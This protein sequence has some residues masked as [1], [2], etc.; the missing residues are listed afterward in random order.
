MTNPTIC[1]VPDDS[2]WRDVLASGATAVPRWSSAEAPV[3]GGTVTT[4][5]AV[6]AELAAAVFAQAG[7]LGV[8]PDALLLAA[9]ARVLAALTAEP[10]VLAGVEV[11]GR[12]LPCRLE[13]GVASWRVLV[14]TAFGA[15]T[16][17]RATD[18]TEDAALARARR[19]LAG[20]WPETVLALDP[21]DTAAETAA[22]PSLDDGVVFRIDRPADDLLRV[23]HRPGDLDAAAAERIAGY[24]LAA[25][26][27]LCADPDA[28]P[29]A[30]GLVGPDELAF[31]VDGLAGP[32]RERPAKPA[33]EIFRDRA[34]ADPDRVAVVNGERSWT[35]RELDE[36]TDRVARAILARG[37]PA[38]GIVAVVAERTLDWAAS[39]LGILKAGA[40]YLPLEP[41]FPADRIATV[42]TR[43]DARLVLG[44]RG[45]TA[46]LD[47][48]LAGLGA[49]APER[50][51][52]DDAV[53]EEHGDAVPRVDIAGDRLAYLYF[54]SGSTGEPKGAMCEHA[55]MVNH[56][57]AKIEDLGI[58][59]GTVVTETAPQCFDISLWQLV[60]P[61]LVGATTV[62]VEQATILDVPAFVELLARRRVEV[63][64]LVPSYLDVVVSY[65]EQQDVPAAEVLPAL[66]RIAVTG[67]AV[68]KELVARW[69]SVRPDVAMV[70][71]YGLTET[72][73]DTNHEILTEVPAGERVPLGPA[74]PNVRVYV[75]DEAL[76]PVPLGAPGEIVFSGVCVGRGY[77]NDPDRTAKA[78]VPDPLRAGERLYR[79]GD[80]GRWL[81]SGKLDFLGRRDHQVKISGFRIEIGEVENTLLR[82]PGV[83]DAAVV[84]AERP[85]R[86]KQLVGFYGAAAPVENEVLRATLGASLPGYMV[87]P[88]LHH[89]EVLPLTPNGKID[90]KALTTLA[91]ALDEPETAADADTTPLSPTEERVAAVW[92]P[93][94]GVDV[95]A[96]GRDT[97][98]FDRGGSSL[99][100]VKMAVGLKKVVS[101]PD[102]V[103]HPVLADLAALI[104]SKAEVPAQAPAPA[105]APAAA[106][107]AEEAPTVRFRPSDLTP[108]T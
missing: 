66:R 29:D 22:E 73:D 1:A 28:A 69:F 108:S 49:A 70:N 89:Q 80:H 104:D 97:H 103:G 37:L 77:V 40:A 52:V 101:L 107:P 65:L 17:L 26:G 100:A 68:K 27:Q 21:A 41:H 55:G 86:G 32:V 19:D 31:L 84:V 82:A 67:E 44:E 63:A 64:Q 3:G 81:P 11:A 96:I 33:H 16:E 5:V 23:V 45:S 72:C 9:H 87:P 90:R 12:T 50:L 60:A 39:V 38:E 47:E 34:A 14:T 46:T 10:E 59:E 56:L 79:S 43:A 4:A 92:A 95:S 51:L 83:R 13:T 91:L 98:F 6:P 18:R 57:Y 71:A 24:H 25:L 99:L 2:R 30:A 48:A 106:A 102:I 58:T 74:V 94:L 105:A 36:V 20:L 85:G 76:H 7:R 61:W 53:A 88:V 78:F 75:V 15:L 8:V 54:T 42:L 93:L 62:I 35:Y